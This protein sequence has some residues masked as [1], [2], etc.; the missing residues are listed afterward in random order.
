MTHDEASSERDRADRRRRPTS[1]RD[2]LRGSG[3]RKAPRRSQDRSGSYFV[4]RFDAATLA[5]IVG[6][7]ALT[8]ADGVL[9]IELLD[10]NSEE[11]NP[12]MA[13]LLGRGHQTFLAGKYILTAAG[14]PFL[15]VFKNYRL[16]GTRFR[17][18]YLFPAFI[19]LYVVLLSYQ[20][21]ML[22]WASYITPRSPYCFW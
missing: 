17:V 15:V 13:H 10:V 12:F 7:L 18:G 16:F 9:T 19:G 3:R 6:L 21:S 11:V 5:M 1:P 8:I 20:W 2:A 4:D 14:L 22:K